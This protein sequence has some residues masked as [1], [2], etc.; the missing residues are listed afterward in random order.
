MYDTYMST[1]GNTAK[2][3]AIHSNKHTA[4]SSPSLV[5][6]EPTMHNLI[7]YFNYIQYHVFK[8]SKKYLNTFGGQYYILYNT[9]Y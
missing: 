7:M 8:Y 3:R 5:E 2:L 4:Q 9:W 1:P 6:S